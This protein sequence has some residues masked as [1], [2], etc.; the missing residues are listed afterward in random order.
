MIRIRR[1][2]L[3]L[4]ILSFNALVTLRL[5]DWINQNNDPRKT[6]ICVKELQLRYV[7]PLLSSHNESSDYDDVEDVKD[8]EMPDR[9]VHLNLSTTRLHIVNNKGTNGSPITSHNETV[10]HTA[11]NK[12]NETEI[13]KNISNHTSLRRT[14]RRKSKK[15]STRKFNGP[16]SCDKCFMRS[17]RYLNL[18]RNVCL[19]ETSD[20]RPLLDM[21]MTVLS[22]PRNFSMRNILRDTW[23]SATRG[24][25]SP[26]VRHVFLLGAPSDEQTQSLIDAEAK[27]KND[28]VQMSF[29]DSYRNLTLKTLM[30]L[31]WATTFCY[32]ARYI[33]KV[34]EDVFSNIPVLIQ[35]TKEG[36]NVRP[37]SILG[38]VQ[39]MR[40]YPI[41]SREGRNSKWFVTLKEYPRSHYPPF[42][43]GPRYLV[44]MTIASALLNVSLSTPFLH[45]ED[46]YMGLL[47]EKTRYDVANV[48]SMRTKGRLPTHCISVRRL[49]TL[50]MDSNLPSL[51]DTWQRC[52]NSLA[53]GRF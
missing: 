8:F 22:V 15:H 52:F 47:L 6:R 25:T 51:N 18:P 28:I 27:Q 24:N 20:G 43:A 50:H 33:Y 30:M 31:N 13:L 35:I 29:V 23:V 37:T 40:R 36:A 21:V 53:P 7:I 39:Y 5:H 48:R 1:T 34:D 12:K 41:R 19:H 4:M 32:N 46:V 42:A 17:Y 45:L 10:L 26:S 44:P 14:L 49:T 3:V 16:F 38:D 9:N 2:T 11:G